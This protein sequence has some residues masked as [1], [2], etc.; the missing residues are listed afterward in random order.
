MLAALAVVREKEIGS[1]IKLYVTPVTRAEF[2]LG[3]QLPYVAL[4]MV[5]FVLMTLMVVFLFGVPIKGS[6][7]ALT[8]A[9]L[10]FCFVATGMGLLASAITKSQIAVLFLAMVGRLIPA[11][12]FGGM[13]DLVSSLEGGGRMVGEAYLPVISG[14]GNL[15]F[16][17]VNA[18]Y[19]KGAMILTSNRGFAEWGDIFGRPSIWQCP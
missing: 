4:A 9:S 2:L 16:Q 15:F 5:N 18:R 14:G 19:E 10:L 12:I 1:I 17:F 11:T 7:L 13:T 6:V 3:K 8:L